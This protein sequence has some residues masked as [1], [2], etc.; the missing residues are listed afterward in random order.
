M[1]LK[2]HDIACFVAN[3]EDKAT[4]L[5]RIA[6][7][8]NVG[9]DSIVFVDD[10]PVERA[11]I[12][13]E[14]PDVLLPDL[15]EDPAGDCAAIEAA[16]AFPMHRLTEEDLEAFFGD[17]LYS[18]LIWLCSVPMCR[19]HPITSPFSAADPPVRSID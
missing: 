3:F 15:P 10:N 11:W 18:R 19:R 9:L 17:G 12:A 4:N 13:R 2:E 8:L 16:K 5:R 6:Q 1:V 7:T 14:L